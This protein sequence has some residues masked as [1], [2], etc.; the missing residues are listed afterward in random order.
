MFFD[1]VDWFDSVHPEILSKFLKE[2]DLGLILSF[3]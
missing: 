2:G 3:L 1:S